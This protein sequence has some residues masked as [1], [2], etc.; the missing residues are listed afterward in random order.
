MLSVS[1]LTIAICDD[2][3]QDLE[4]IH[5]LIHHHLKR[6][7]IS[8]HISSYHNTASLLAD[9]RSG[10][11]FHILFLDVLMDE[12]NGLEFAA[13][14]RRQQNT[15]PI[16]F[17]SVNQEFALSGYEVSAVRYLAKPVEP[18]KLDEALHRCLEI[19]NSKK[20]ILLPT[21]QG[22]HRISVSDIQFIE[23]FDRGILVC[24]GSEII[25]CR[26]K[27]REAETLMPLAAF[28]Q[29]HRSYLVNPDHIKTIRPYEFV[30]RSGQRIPVGKARYHEI[31]KQFIQY[32]SS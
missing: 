28:I 26:M 4:H 2:T 19:W 22:E 21:E 24:M 23:A 31:R 10:K 15:T 5:T 16:V 1:K 11:T 17:M 12:M 8:H 25:E 9:I 18:R 6:G 20:E 3:P 32:L 7:G 29:C 30:L 14:L 13:L 27:F